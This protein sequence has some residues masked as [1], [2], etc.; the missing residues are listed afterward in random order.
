MTYLHSIIVSIENIAMYVRTIWTYEIWLNWIVVSSR[1]FT[2]W[3]T[4][5]IYNTFIDSL[6]LRQAL[7]K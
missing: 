7:L 1:K 6:I 3:P 4:L 5:F 2:A